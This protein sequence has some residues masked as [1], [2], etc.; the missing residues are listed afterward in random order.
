M[1]I[2]EF[3][4]KFGM[5]PDGIRYYEKKGLLSPT[6]SEN[7][8]RQY[9]EQ[10]E[11][12]LQFI[13]VLKQL[14][15]KLDEISLLLHMQEQPISTECNQMTTSFIEQKIDEVTLQMEFYSKAQQILLHVLQLMNENRYSENKE[16]IERLISTMY[17][18]SC[19]GSDSL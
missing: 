5:T 1:K 16:V 11:Q 3:A 14:G 17:S 15:F 7:G 13:V 2:K 19:T 6:K 4:Q 18:T 12:V 8:Y 10:H 9:N